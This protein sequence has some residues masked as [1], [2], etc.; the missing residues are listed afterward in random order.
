MEPQTTKQNTWAIPLAIVIAGALVAGAVFLSGKKQ[1]ATGKVAQKPAKEV[2]GISK[3]DHV[4]GNPN[5]PIVFVEYS[6]LQCPFCQDF[7]KT[8]ERVMAKYAKDGKVAWV[9]RHFW[10]ERKDAKGNIF[11]PLAGKAAEAS[12]CAKELG[13]ETAFWSFIGKIFDTQESQQALL[14]NLSGVAESVGIEKASFDKCLS[15]G[16]YTKVI[17]KTFD[18]ARTFGV[19][20]TPNTFIMSPQGNVLIPG[21]TDEAELINII[22]SLSE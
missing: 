13:G 4:L 19:T 1:V 22:E 7:H 21:A 18:E 14:K 5:A 20:A 8:M 12:E 10:S 3:D 17:K 6:D 15:S 11:H 16:K 2:R 9:Y